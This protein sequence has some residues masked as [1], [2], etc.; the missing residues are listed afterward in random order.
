MKAKETLTIV[1]E[2][3]FKHHSQGFT[4]KI[5]KD[6]ADGKFSFENDEIILGDKK[7]RIK[8]SGPPGPGDRFVRR[9]FEIYNALKKQPEFIPYV[10]NLESA[11]RT[12][13]NKYIQNR[14]HNPK[15]PYLACYGENAAQYRQGIEEITATEPKILVAGAICPYTIEQVISFSKIYNPNIYVADKSFELE[16]LCKAKELDALIYTC[17]LTN[18]QS[19]DSLPDFNIVIGDRLMH[20]L[21]EENTHEFI[22]NMREREAGLML[23][24]HYES[25]EDKALYN[26]IKQEYVS[27]DNTNR[28]NLNKSGVS[29]S[30]LPDLYE[31]EQRDYKIELTPN[32][33]IF[34][35]LVKP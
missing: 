34:T 16:K 2:D 17:D 23:I 35:L 26:L 27:K 15:A 30:Y 20:E 5:A 7:T 29:F 3:I 14:V 9:M 10:D 1:G 6:F 31:L 18:R 13:E 21:P 32:E 25:A 28:F 12:L 33:N 24:N 11:M 8:T 4:K 22:R 19:I